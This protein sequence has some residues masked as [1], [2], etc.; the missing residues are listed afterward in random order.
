MSQES[1]TVKEKLER[2]IDKKWVPSHEEKKKKH[3]DKLAQLKEI[4]HLELAILEAVKDYVPEKFLKEAA[5]VYVKVRDTN[6]LLSMN[7]VSRRLTDQPKL[8][9][10]FKLMNAVYRYNRDLISGVSSLSTVK[11]T[12]K[13]ST[14]CPHCGETAKTIL[15]NMMETKA[16]KLPD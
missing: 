7:K 11:S 6:S 13:T 15:H 4:V 2:V 12:I 10:V 8:R 3:S 14:H 9:N 1:Q 16:V 5:K